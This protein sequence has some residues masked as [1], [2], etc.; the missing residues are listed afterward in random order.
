MI[1]FSRWLVLILSLGV[2]GYGLYAYLALPP[3]TSVHPDMKAAYAAHPGRIVAHV[4]FSALA[5][6][7]GPLQFFPALRARR[8]LHRGLGYLYFLGVMGGGIAGFCTA[9]IAY[10]G[11]VAR[12][13]FGML[14]LVWLWTALA[15][16]HAARR[17]DFEAHERW[18][19]R[20]F[21]LTFAAVTLRLYMPL[22]FAA[23][24]AFEDFY[25]VQA[26]L[27]WVPNLILLEW[28]LLGRAKA[29]K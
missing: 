26:W 29:Q 24:I 15:A 19:L 2:T 23:G 5:L 14:A 22:F 11:L 20:S 10:G 13:G 4:A 6:A 1:S 3:G 16:I 7:V 12:V 9:F 18:A 28:M 21:A 25:P 27:C 8:R 17:R